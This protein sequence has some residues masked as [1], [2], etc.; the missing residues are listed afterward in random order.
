[1]V[2]LFTTYFSDSIST[3]TL[4]TVENDI[5]SSYGTSVGG[6]SVDKIMLG[7]TYPYLNCYVTTNYSGAFTEATNTFDGTYAIRISKTRY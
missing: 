2:Q 3:S 5:T 6:G 4:A 1:M 7:P